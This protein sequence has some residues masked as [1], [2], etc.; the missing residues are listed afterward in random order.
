MLFR[1]ELED[2]R[3]RLAEIRTEFARAAE[4][5]RAVEMEVGRLR[6]QAQEL[7]AA[8][9]EAESALQIALRDEALAEQTRHARTRDRERLDAE[10][11]EVAAEEVELRA[12]ADRLD[13][14]LKRLRRE[15]AAATAAIAALDEEEKAQSRQFAEARA[16]QASA[17]QELRSLD[18]ALERR[19]A[20]LRAIQSQA[21]E[22]SAR[23]RELL[24]NAAETEAQLEARIGELAAAESALEVLEGRRREVEEGHAVLVARRRTLEVSLAAAS[25][26][27]GKRRVGKECRSRWSPY[28]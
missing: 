21:A 25:D 9:R 17:E 26:E 6:R 18:R 16:A 20:V 4:I 24:A 23:L 8:R 3:H 27:I 7:A 14:E 19:A 28:H 10:E 2:A 1:S 22:R 5:T 12:A 15:L 11:S 13:P